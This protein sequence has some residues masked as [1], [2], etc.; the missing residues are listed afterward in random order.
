MVG[1]LHL[2]APRDRSP[3]HTPPR[4]S[5][6]PSPSSSSQPRPWH[7][8]SL[9]RRRGSPRGPGHDPG[10]RRQVRPRHLKDGKEVECRVTLEADDYILTRR[11]SKKKQYARDEIA[12]IHSV[13]RSLSQ[14]FERYDALPSRG[15]AELAELALFCEQNELPSEARNLWIQVLTIDLR[16][17]R[18]GTSSAASTPSAGAGGSRCAGASTPWTSFASASPTGSTP[19]R[20]PRRT[21]C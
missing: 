19:W 20:S 9:I 1:M 10:A 15:P 4:P 2:P 6:A 12:E 5:F 13:E 11:G 3:P 16:T 18:P 7:T 17:S 8:R 21:S 14:L